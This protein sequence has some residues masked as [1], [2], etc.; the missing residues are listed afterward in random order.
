M[1]KTLP[2]IAAFALVFSAMETKAQLPDGS[3]APDWTLTDYVTGT[4]HNL[5][6]YLNAGK[7][8]V[9]DFSATWCGPC[10]SYHNSNAM[11]NF[12][13]QYGPPG[14]NQVM[15]FFIEADGSTNDPCMTNSAG[16]TGGTQGN[17]ITGTPYPMFNPASAVI[18]PINSGYQIGYYPTCYMICP[19]K[20]T[21]KVDQ[22][23]TTQL[24]N[25]MM[26]KC[27]PPTAALDAG[28]S[29]VTSPNGFACGTS[30]TPVV[31]VRNFGSSPLTSCTINFQVDANPAQT[32]AWTGNLT[33]GQTAIATLPSVSVTL[34]SHTFTSFTSNPNGGSDGNTANDQKVSNFNAV[35]NVNP[36]VTEGME[37][38]LPSA[39]CSVLNPDGTTTFVKSAPGGFGTSS[40]SAKIDCYNYAT[41]GEMDYLVM[42][43][44]SLSGATSSALT[45]NVAYRPY[46]ATYFE[47][48]D[49]EI[50][51]NCGTTWT[52]VYSKSGTTLGTAAAST[53]AFTPT[54]AQWRA[55]NINL[56]TYLGQ[57]SVMAQLKCTNGYGNNLYIDDINITSVVSVDEI[58]LSSY[59]TVYPNPSAGDV[60]VTIN[61]SNLGNVSV[62][63]TD[64]MGKVIAEASENSAGNM[65]FDL[66]EQSNGMYFV[67]VKAENGKMI[68][69]VMLNK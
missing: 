53:T 5:Y 69:K 52:N 7:V 37:T 6:S 60:Y 39:N 58:D 24:Y 45:F 16:C 17:W 64:V 23:T 43:P 9:V 12:Y 3:T 40:N 28:I 65:K 66:S 32:F 35:A 36:P 44:V 27:P 4:S 55:E 18:N 11:E 31:T 42:P 46:D 22:Y 61:A 68:Q 41:T 21:T 59:V 13:N 10:W 26:S 51:T 20:K 47:K 48:L 34:G 29:L 62:A 25:T 1:K 50:S 67:V 14:T 54:A 63:I 30:I 19:D 2:L 8:V 49:V 33:T 15:V 56:S 57:P 38:T